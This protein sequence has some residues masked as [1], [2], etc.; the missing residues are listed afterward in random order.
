MKRAVLFAGFGFLYLP[1]ML[2]ALYSFNSSR[3]VTVWAGVST[4]WYGALWNDAQILDAAGLSLVVATISATLA[5]ILGTAAG[6]ALARFGAF[7]GRLAFTGLLAAPL[8]M[9]DIIAGLSLLLMFVALEQM[10]G[11]P[12]RGVVTLVIAHA[13]AGLPYVAVVVQARAHAQDRALEEAAADLGAPPA[14]VFWRITLPLLMPAVIAGW[15]LAFVLSIDDLVIAS[16]VTGPQATTLPMVVFSA[17]RLG[18]SPK[19]NALATLMLLASLA[20]LALAWILLR[21]APSR[22]HENAPA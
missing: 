10:F 3:L 13:T 8:A 2:V 15:L 4:H 16:F 20:V 18:V 22:T 1:L 12:T 9:P 17:I 21:R 6:L 7:R 14:T 5:A 19:I 11:F